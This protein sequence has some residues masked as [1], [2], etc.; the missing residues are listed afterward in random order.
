MLFYS[1]YAKDSLDVTSYFSFDVRALL[2]N[3]MNKDVSEKKHV[4]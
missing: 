3:T 2:L 4:G 1:V